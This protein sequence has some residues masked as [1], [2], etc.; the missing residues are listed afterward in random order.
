MPI[1]VLVANSTMDETAE[2]YEKNDIRCAPLS[3]TIDG[4]TIAEDFGKTL[5]F[6]E[7]FDKLRAG[8]M[9]STSQAKVED[10]LRI[11]REACAAGMDVLYVGFSSGLSGSYDAGCMAAAE[12]RPEFPDRVIRCVDTLSAAGGEYILVNRAKELRDQG[13]TADEV[14]D[15]IERLRLRMIHLVTV[16]D[17]K[18]LWR[19]GRVSKTSAYV[20]SLIGIKPI[21]FV[22]DEGKLQVCSKVRGRRKALELLA[23][24]VLA[25]ITDRDVPVRI[26]HGDCEEDAQ[27][28]ADYLKEKGGLSSEI[29]MIDTVLG[30]HTGPGVMTV[31]FVGEKRGPV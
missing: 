5:P 24:S 20:G 22:D 2:Y 17:L 14:G 31:F 1:F 25:Q 29:R 15:E 28:V 19:G 4:Q 3:F 9:S 7:F 21:I 27:Y 8:H 26:S 10:Y 16:D 18:H 6:K 12:V 23:D 13:L 11:F 30:S